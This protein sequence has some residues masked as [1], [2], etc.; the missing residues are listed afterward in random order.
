MFPSFNGLIRYRTLP[1][2]GQIPQTRPAG[3]PDP[4][5]KDENAVYRVTQ[6]DVKEQH[7]SQMTVHV[8]RL[9]IELAGFESGHYAVLWPRRGE[10]D[11]GYYRAVARDS[12]S[13][14]RHSAGQ[15]R[16]RLPADPPGHRRHLS[17]AL[18]DRQTSHS[19]PGCDQRRAAAVHRR[20]LH[21]GVC[22]RVS[23]L[24]QSVDGPGH[25]PVERAAGFGPLR[26]EPARDRRGASLIDRL[27]AGPGRFGWQG[28]R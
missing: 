8:K 10:S 20:L 25:R 4:S 14:R 13:D 18:R 24:V 1:I 23:R 3:A 28:Q 9:P 26:H 11:P 5:P 6:P 27:P 16:A 15:P 21:H 2:D 12:R 7:D 22:D 17:R 19:E